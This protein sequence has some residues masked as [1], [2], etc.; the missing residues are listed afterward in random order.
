MN[1]AIVHFVIGSSPIITIFPYFMLYN[2]HNRL[3][4][5]ER[6]SSRISFQTLCVALPILY[7]MIFAILYSC[8]GFIPRKT[9]NSTYTRFIICGSLTSLLVSLLLHYLFHIHQEWFGIENPNLYHIGTFVFYLVLFYT[10]GQ[11]L[12]A[13]LLYGPPAKTP[14]LTARPPTINTPTISTSTQMM[15]TPNPAHASSALKFDEI[16]NAKKATT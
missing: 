4:D 12:R 14:I 3:T 16:K 10:I 8:C 1:D 9:G 5:E 11:W 6:K 13:Q 15:N 2:A 7:G